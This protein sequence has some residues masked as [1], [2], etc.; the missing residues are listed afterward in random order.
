M[1]L[2]QAN[3]VLV[4][5]L[6]VVTWIPCKWTLPNEAQL[7]HLLNQWTSNVV[8]TFPAGSLF[9]YLPVD[10]FSTIS[11]PPSCVCLCVRMCTRMPQVQASCVDITLKKLLRFR[12]RLAVLIYQTQEMKLLFRYRPAFLMTNR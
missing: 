4:I 1:G 3:P 10:A 6:V 2:G 12:Y 8:N 5:V 11:W 7:L 9:L